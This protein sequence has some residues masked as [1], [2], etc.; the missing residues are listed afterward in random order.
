MSIC[1]T[2]DPANLKSFL[3]FR[4][5]ALTYFAFRLQLPV[6]KQYIF[7]IL[8]RDEGMTGSKLL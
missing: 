3:N 6:N 1:T 4:F 2:G 8:A 5:L 7:F